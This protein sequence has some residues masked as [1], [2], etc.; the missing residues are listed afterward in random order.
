M[1]YH[2]DLYYN[3]IGWWSKGKLDTK[4]TN[5]NEAIRCYFNYESDV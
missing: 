3:Q 2:Y 1:L 4:N 5:M